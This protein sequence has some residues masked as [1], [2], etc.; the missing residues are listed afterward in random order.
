V[1]TFRKG[2]R[3]TLAS[4]D[5]CGDGTWPP[6]PV[7][8]ERPG[9]SGYNERAESSLPR[10]GL[11]EP[12]DAMDSRQRPAG[13]II[14]W[15]RAID[16]GR[17]LITMTTFDPQNA[18]EQ[19]LEKAATDPSHRPQ[20]YR[21]LTAAEFFIVQPTPPAGRSGR[22]VTEAQE[23][24]K[25]GQIEW[26]GKSFIPVFS[27]LKRLE[28]G[29]TEPAG[30]LA[31]NAMEFMKITKG[32]NLLLNPG[33]AFGKELPA[34]EISS[35]LDGTIWEPSERVETKEEEQVLIGQPARYPE[36][37]V[38]ALARYFS[39]RKSVR[40]AFIAMYFNP[41]RDEK[42]HTLIAIEVTG[43]WEPVVA[44][45]GMIAREVSVPDPPVDFMQISGRGG[46]EEH[47]TK[48]GQPFYRRKFLGMF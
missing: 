41:K 30:F 15:S 24:I 2:G 28:A 43:E 4:D 10:S 11:L 19:S 3:K 21:D 47:F 33:A 14:P 36:E 20:F 23:S 35:I 42:P 12:P 27:S 7:T 39:T 6:R 32:A 1:K 16:R 44:G 34:E 48:G 18:F 45:A 38:A 9:R 5:D 46:I 40:R 13:W 29:L 8:P 26:N 25:V 17:S 37:L 22:R 31:I